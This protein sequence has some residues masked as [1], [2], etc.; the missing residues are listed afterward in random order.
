MLA[1]LKPGGRSLVEEMDFHSI[2]PDAGLDRAT[3][4]LFARVIDAHHAVLAEQHALICSVAAALTE[5]SRP[6]GWAQVESEGR[7][8]IW[9]GGQP[10][11]TIWRLTPIQLRDQLITQGRVT[12]AEGST[13]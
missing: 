2:A 1:A 4:A 9:R 6:Q 5:P 7:L 12:A 10:G 13:P 11:G 3:Q 8:S